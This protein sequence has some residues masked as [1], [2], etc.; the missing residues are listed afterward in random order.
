M[1]KNNPKIILALFSMIIGILIAIQMK[2]KVENYAPVTI[3]A[4]QMT[5]SEIIN[6]NNEIKEL[7]QIINA[8]EEE[9]EILDNISKGDENIIDIFSGDIRNNKMNSGRA[10]LKGPGITISMYDNSEERGFGFDLN[11]DV[12]HDIDILNIINDLR[13]AGAEAISINGERIISTSKIKCGGPIIRINERSSAP[14]FVIK[15]IGDP[16]LLNAS[17]N[18][19]GTNGD[20]LKNVYNKGFETTTEDLITIPGYKGIFNFKYAK[21]LGEGD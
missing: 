6:I 5:K 16:K 4:L 20:I 18:A 21:P 7:K 10:D 14:P 8:K 11:Y 17:V 9:L 2:I 19:P 3:N 15:A 12:I 1:K 13:V